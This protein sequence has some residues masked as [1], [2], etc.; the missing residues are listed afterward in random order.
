[1][2]VV[3]KHISPLIESQFPAFYK[4]Q[5]P[6]FVLFVEEY[7]KWLES[8]NTLYASYDDTIIDG[9]PL[10]HS[11]KLLEYRDID[12]TVEEFVLFIKEKYL[13]NVQFESGISTRR[14]VKASKDLFNSKGSERSLEL[15]FQM[16]YGTKIEIYTP[17]SD[18]LKPSD[19]TWVLPRYL[20]LTQSSRNVDYVGKQITGSSSGASAFV[21]YLVTRNING[22]FIDVM[23]LSKVD[24]DFITGEVVTDNGILL[25]APK[26][27]GSLSNI[28]ITVPGEL[29]TVGEIVSVN[30]AS[31][32]EGIA[33][34]T[35]VDS[36]TGIVRF[37]IVDGGWGYSLS[38]QTTISEKTIRISGVTNS[39]SSITGFFR[40]E[41]ITQNLYSFS[42]TDVPDI[43]EVGTEFNNG[44][45]ATPSL[46]IGV[47]AS[48][49]TSTLYTANTATLILN[50]ITNNV[51]S[52]NSIFE[53]NRAIIITDSSVSFNLND[54]V[55]QSNGSTNSVFGVIDSVSNTTIL[56]VNTATIG[57]NGIHV[58]TFIEQA[59]SGA[60]GYIAAIPRE[61]NFTFTNVSVTAV[62]VVSGT[63][64]NTSTVTAYSNSSKTLT[65]T[66]FVPT[67]ARTGTRY[68]LVNTNLTT[69]TRW[70]TSNTVI[71]V[72][73]PTTNN[74]ILL[75]TDIGGISIASVNASASANVFAQNS[76][77][78]GITSSTNTFFATGKTVVYGVDSNTFANIVSI[79][80]GSG[81]SFN[82]GSISDSETVRLSPDFISSN[83]DGPG[84]SSVKFR[85]MIISGANS[86]YG[87]LNSVFIESGGT[88][89]NNT[90]IV[91]FSGGNSGVGSFTAGDASI[92]TNGSGVITSVGLTSNVGNLIITT[93]SVSIVNATGGS[94]GVGTGASLI[95]VS[96]LG[97]IKL[98][99]ADITA[100]LI[101]VLRFNTTTI[102]SI[103]SLRSVNPGENYNANP[104]VSVYEPDVVSYG[105]R[106]FIIYIDIT[107][108][109]GYTVGELVTQTIS[110]P[111]VRITSN[112]FTGNS[113]L[114]YEV[115]EVVYSTDGISNTATGIIYST[116]RDAL[117]G[118][119]TTV[120][121]SNTGTW[122]N[123][124]NV[125]VLTVLSNTSF[126]PNSKVLQGTSA[127][128]IL[129]SSN[130]TTLVVR[131]VLGTF[132]AGAVT[133]NVGGSTTASSSTNT[134]IYR[135]IGLTSNGVSNISNTAAD[136]ASALA[137]GRVKSGNTS[138]IEVK[139]VSL[140][141]DFTNGGTLVGT[142]SGT[143]ATIL[144]EIEDSSTLPAG[145]NAIITANV[146]ASEGRIT[147]LEV[148]DSGLGYIDTESVQL[149][150]LDGLRAANGQ[151]DISK[152]GIGT[153]YY[154]S[155]RG[156]LDDNKFIFDG[157]YY[158]NYSYEVQSSIPL[159]KYS[160]V[161]KTVLHISGKKLFGRVV[162]APSAN[163]NVTANSTVTI[164]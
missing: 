27:I 150:S 45:T 112:T 23:F 50:Q 31:G 83:N 36:V 103:T 35:G 10:Y 96:S 20:E 132:T 163:I 122:R 140:F 81:A 139:R 146:V 91:R 39:N 54:A 124:I 67:R 59:T 44:N 37:E 64:N 66:T 87:N 80:T 121:T 138:V 126:N 120:L 158:Q 57:S 58:G 154:S 137:Q 22:K 15:F 42:L 46:S 148:T 125:S 52:N 75:A 25:N 85:D 69:N 74:T 93:P 2:S 11:R 134:S 63:F 98:P 84:S 26:I 105:K 94:I 102:G 142:T 161:L 30:S 82:I 136:T 157:D 116:T 149:L 72:G 55:V 131:D 100:R 24:G 92:I 12:S 17:G 7:Y 151:A 86:T 95:P 40:N 49:N 48:Q 108:G 106:D 88:G 21:E 73:T 162:S 16:L 51:F 135:L 6:V 47:F 144:S 101:D 97:F 53:K 8:N 107:S 29:F 5:G 77:F 99:R 147:S 110:T 33:R 61:N 159:D 62:S 130:S 156:F 118:V 141:T 60:T 117:S 127:N 152:Q 129:V 3:E 145:D 78:I 71:L 128:G 133:S 19:G 32:V 153:G 113:S 76:S 111:G 89:Y 155:T 115:S 1:M 109:A 56:D 43:L 41:N 68:V 9:N 114:S 38:A 65:L 79:S 18:I 4:E 160:E 123:T 104:F 28:N 164:S 13:K 143:Q 90:N 34:V 14:I 119:Y 70:S